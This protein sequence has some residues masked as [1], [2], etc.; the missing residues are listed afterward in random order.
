MAGESLIVG[1]RADDTRRYLAR[2][3]NMGWD[4]KP[5]GRCIECGRP[6]FLNESGQRAHRERDSLLICKFDYDAGKRNRVE[7]VDYL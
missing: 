7:V 5:D 1:Y 4:T 6:V 2:T 3:Y